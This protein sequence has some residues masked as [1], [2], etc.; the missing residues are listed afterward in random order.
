MTRDDIAK[1][2]RNGRVFAQLTQHE[3]A[4]AHRCTVTRLR[5]LEAGHGLG[6]VEAVL[7][8]LQTYGLKVSV[9]PYNPRNTHIQSEGVD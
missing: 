4:K 7:T 9:G 6:G 5:N 8:M 2:L 3:A 1:L